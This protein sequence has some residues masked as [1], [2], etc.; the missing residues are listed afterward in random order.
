VQAA[1]V[2]AP[3]LR[4]VRLADASVARG[5]RITLKLRASEAVTLRAVVHKRGRSGRY[6]ATA[7]GVTRRTA[8]GRLTLQVPTRGLAAGRYRLVVTATD[9]AGNRSAASRVGFALTR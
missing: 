9:A 3:Q 4:G 6:T 1:D 8:A 7:R 5:T 2:L